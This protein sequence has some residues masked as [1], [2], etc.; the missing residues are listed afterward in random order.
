MLVKFK[1]NFTDNSLGYA[2]DIGD[3]VEYYKLYSD[4]MSF[5][6][7]HYGEKIYE[8]QYETLTLEQDRETRK[9]I[10]HL[11]LEW[12]NKCLKP[13]NN[14][15]Y[16]NTNSSIQIRKGVYQ[17]SSED[18]KTYKQYLSKHFHSLSDANFLS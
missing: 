1:Q 13:Q 9:M 12:E 3:I 17:G 18:W 5:W 11:G 8:L 16:I 2:Y 10:S 6:G 15:R 7:R 14:L 4:I